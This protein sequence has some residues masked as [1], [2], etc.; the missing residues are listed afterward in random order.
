MMTVK[1]A[2][3]SAPGTLEVLAHPQYQPGAGQA[4]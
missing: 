1:G 3:A 4:L 2:L